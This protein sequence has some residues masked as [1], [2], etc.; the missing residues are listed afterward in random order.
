[1]ADL[2]LSASWC[3]RDEGR[4]DRERDCQTEAAL[5]FESALE[6]GAVEPTQVATILYLV[7]ELYR[8]LGLFE[9]AI[10]YFDQALRATQT[11]TGGP[12]TALVARQRRLAEG[13]RSDNMT[14]D[15]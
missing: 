13:H 3:A 14:I 7:G 6:S 15:I 8:R 9:V 1:M 12:V 2:F 10:S 4:P 5:R 11:D